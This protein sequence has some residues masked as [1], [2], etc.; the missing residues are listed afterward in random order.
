MSVATV[1]TLLGDHPSF[2]RQVATGDSVTVLFRL[3]GGR[4]PIITDSFACTVEGAAASPTL[5]S[6]TG[7]VTFATAPTGAIVFTFTYAEISDE[8][9][10]ALLALESDPYSAAAIAAEAI[11]GRYSSSVDRKIGDLSISASQKAKQWSDKAKALRVAGRNGLFQPFAGGISVS[12]K[13]TYTDNPDIVQPA[14]TRTLH[15]YEEA[16]A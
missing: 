8:S 2:L 13:T 9:I 7:I 16:E 10:T 14:F 4:F 11:A 6:E 15:D 1:R 12:G 5:D 3:N